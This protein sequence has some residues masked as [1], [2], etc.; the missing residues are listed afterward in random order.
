MKT[1][2][3]FLIYPALIMG[4]ILMLTFSCKKDDNSNDD[5]IVKDRDGNI[6]HTIKIGTQTWMLENL[7]TTKYSNGDPIPNVIDSLAW[8]NLITGAYCNFNNDENNSVIYGRLYNW[9]SVNDSRKLA[10]VGWHVPNDSEWRTLTDY[11]GGEEHAGSKLKEAGNA[12]WFDDN[13]D[14]TNES[15]F[16]GLPGGQ[17]S[18]NYNGQFWDLNYFGYWW[19]SQENSPSTSFSFILYTSGEAA[20]QSTLKKASG[21][22][23]RCLKDN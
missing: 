11:L 23:V 2:T 4:V 5:N 17:R 18:Y 8:A 10:P 7:K 21:F 15:G 22:S 16:T 20:H 3:K 14:A 19:S 12:H 1:K 6:Y 13:S 9:Y